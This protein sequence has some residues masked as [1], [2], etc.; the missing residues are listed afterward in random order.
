M[1][2]NLYAF[3][4]NEILKSKKTK[5]RFK[6]KTLQLLNQ[7]CEQYCSK[8]TK[9]S[10]KLPCARNCFVDRNDTLELKNIIYRHCKTD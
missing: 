10:N 7:Y 9:T 5:K 8:T 1:I 3:E 4:L 6:K 2:Y